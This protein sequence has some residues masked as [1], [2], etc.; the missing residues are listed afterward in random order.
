MIIGP[1]AVPVFVYQEQNSRYI[2]PGHLSYTYI[3]VQH[4]LNT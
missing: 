2:L 4:V 1:I 3:S